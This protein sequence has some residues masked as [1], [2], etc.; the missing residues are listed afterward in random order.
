MVADVWRSMRG[1]AGTLHARGGACVHAQVQS[2]IP[3]DARVVVACQ[4]GLRSLAACE[5]LARA[6][7]QQLAWINGGFDTARKGDIAT[8]NGVDVRRVRGARRA[9]GKSPLGRL[10]RGG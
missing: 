6:G 5:Q 4:K 8:T 1:R 2:K 3:K 10:A 7:Y 9:A